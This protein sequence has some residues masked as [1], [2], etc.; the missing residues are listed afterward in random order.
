MYRYFVVLLVIL[1]SKYGCARM[2]KAEHY[3]TKYKEL[4]N[5]F[6]GRLNIRSISSAKSLRS[7]FALRETFGDILFKLLDRE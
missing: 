7:N 1:S 6:S 4:I 5:L 3:K 2:R